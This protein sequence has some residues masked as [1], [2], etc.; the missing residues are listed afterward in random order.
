MASARKRGKLGADSPVEIWPEPPG[1][2]EAFSQLTGEAAKVQAEQ[3]L[4]T[5]VLGSH[6]SAGVVELLLS[7][8]GLRAAAVLPYALRLQ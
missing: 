5:R 8:D 6:V 4:L 2:F 7:G 3:A 1:V